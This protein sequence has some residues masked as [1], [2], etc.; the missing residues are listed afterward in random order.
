[1]GQIAQSHDK[2][3]HNDTRGRQGEFLQWWNSGVWVERNMSHGRE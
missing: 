2:L 1:M 3:V